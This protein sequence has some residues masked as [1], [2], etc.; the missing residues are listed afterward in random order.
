MPEV[1]SSTFSTHKHAIE[2]LQFRNGV[3]N[4]QYEKIASGTNAKKWSDLAAYQSASLQEL[5][6]LI[7]Q[8]SSNIDLYLT[9]S[10][11]KNTILQS[12]D[13]I[14][15][16]IIDARHNAIRARNPLTGNL[17][18]MQLL[19]KQT[20]EA[21][22]SFLS[23]SY[24]GDYMFA[25]L[26]V[27]IQPV[28]DFVNVSNLTDKKQYTNNYYL[29][30]NN[31]ENI[32]AGDEAFQ[33]AIGSLH[34]LIA[35][36]RADYNTAIDWLDESTTSLTEAITKLGYGVQ[37]LEENVSMLEKQQLLLQKEREKIIGLDLPTAMAELNNQIAVLNAS[38][39][40]TSKTQNLSLINYL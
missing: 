8:K 39:M 37:S 19:A 35:G 40:A 6:S 17:I 23:D 16:F 7:M 20:L 36:D 34:L 25:G 15:E 2:T 10:R 30:D 13:N 11:Q 12:L 27:N 26:K 14:R 28:D 22:K 5:D 38:F 33:K 31:G 32:N 21:L 24:E 18:P 9:E 3:V 1:I 4:R 29:G